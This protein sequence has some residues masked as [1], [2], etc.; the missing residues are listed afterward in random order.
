MV[1]QGGYGKVY[2]VLHKTTGAVHAMKCLKKAD[3]IKQ[4][5]LQSLELEKDILLHVKHPFMV[6]MDYIFQNQSYVFFVMDFVEGGE[7]FRHLTNIRRF[8]ED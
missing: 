1:G 4:K 3:I 5:S 7:L 6:S 2:K 8:K